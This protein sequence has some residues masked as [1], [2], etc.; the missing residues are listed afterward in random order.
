M[1][2]LPFPQVE[3]QTT[4]AWTQMLN[5]EQDSVPSAFFIILNTNSVC[6]FLVQIIIT[7]LI[8]ARKFKYFP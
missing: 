8:P 5:T 4:S 2:L 6:I 7:L 1:H 3:S